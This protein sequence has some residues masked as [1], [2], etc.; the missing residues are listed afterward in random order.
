MWRKA[1]VKVGRPHS[2][3]SSD[4]REPGF[5]L[6][7]R[8]IG[9][10]AHCHPWMHGSFGCISARMTAR[11]PGD[12]FPGARI[13]T[14]VQYPPYF[15]L[16]TPYTSFRAGLS[17]ICP[18][19]F[20]RLLVYVQSRQCRAS[21]AAARWPVLKERRSA[22]EYYLTRATTSYGHSGRAMAPWLAWLR[23]S[24]EGGDG[25]PDPAGQVARNN[26]TL[27]RTK[28]VVQPAA[29]YGTKHRVF[30]CVSHC[31]FGMPESNQTTCSGLRSAFTRPVLSAP[32]RAI[33]RS[34]RV[35]S[36]QCPTEPERAPG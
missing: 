25:R 23:Q 29:R 10:S 22:E 15:P 11:L 28:R 35:A 16:L 3:L 24:N 21:G 34:S 13:G 18:T 1:A 4:R 9:I 27:Q 31:R 32:I 33:L 7:P 2:V 30:R 5:P 12:G 26:A 14:L 36:V 17:Q 6:L 8:Q 20:V 19:A